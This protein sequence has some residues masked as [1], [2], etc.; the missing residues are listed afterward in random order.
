MLDQNLVLE[1]SQRFQFSL[2]SLKN[3]CAAGTVAYFLIF[4]VS[5]LADLAPQ[6]KSSLKIKILRG[7]RILSMKSLSPEEWSKFNPATE[8]DYRTERTYGLFLYEDALCFHD[9]GILLSPDT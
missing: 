2:T 4:R 7:I 1:F 9:M 6:V 8:P 5:F 3:V